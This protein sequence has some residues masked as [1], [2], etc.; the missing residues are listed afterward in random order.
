MDFEIYYHYKQLIFDLL[1]LLMGTLEKYQ[2][3]LTKTKYVLTK[4][5]KEPWLRT[6]FSIIIIYYK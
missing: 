3:Y 5:G 6:I 4:E 1:K 2:K